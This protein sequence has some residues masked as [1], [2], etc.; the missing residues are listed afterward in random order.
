MKPIC[1]II[2]P[3]IVLILTA[4]LLSG[5]FFSQDRAVL[6]KTVLTVNGKDVSTKDFAERLALRLKNFDALHAK[7]ESTL[8]RVKEET[9]QAYILEIIAR[10][11]ADKNGIKVSSSEIDEQANEIRSKYP[12]DF[13]FRRALADENLALD[14]WK[15]DLE[16]TILQKKIFAKITAGAKEPTEAELKDYY[17]SHKA[18]FQQTARVRLR[19]VV[20][21]KEDDAKRIYDELANG[22][23]MAKIAK[24]YSVAPEASNGGDTG[25]LD[26]GTM[27]VFDL[28]F[29]MPV[30]SRSKILKSPYGYHIYEVLK[31]EPEGHLS[32]PEAKAKIRSRL[33]E[34]KAQHL[35]S[36]WLEEQVR[37]SSVKRNDAL[38]RAIKVTTRG[39]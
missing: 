31:K 36:A 28:A 39:S 26:K 13:A 38:I 29:K 33:M 5:C 27:D 37:K 20:L 16:F 34:E 7:D 32:F 10:D 30:G 9:V 24:K 4:P 19:Q 23:D 35:F 21:E 18:S 3:A 14:A 12:D 17:E 15:K 8:D 22:A 1:S 2:A 6:N 25:W 11:Y